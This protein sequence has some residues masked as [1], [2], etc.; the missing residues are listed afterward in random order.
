MEDPKTFEILFKGK[1]DKGCEEL[2]GSMGA[3]FYYGFCNNLIK[4]TGK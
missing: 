1:V 3:K 4:F 2:L